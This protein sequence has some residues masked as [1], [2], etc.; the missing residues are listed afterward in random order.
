LTGNYENLEA[1][2][3]LSNASN[4]LFTDGKFES[5]WIR[6]VAAGFGFG[7][8]VDIQNFVIRLDL[9][10][11]FRVPYRPENDRW[12]FPFFGDKGNKMTLN[13]AIGYPF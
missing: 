1:D 7:A 2:Q 4:S 13:F 10:S 12:N 3:Q 8:R 11:P 6:E 5:D 9:A